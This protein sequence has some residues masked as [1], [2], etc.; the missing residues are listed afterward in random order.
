MVDTARAEPFLGDGEAAP[1]L[2]QQIA[3]WNP[4]ILVMDFRVAEIVGAFVTHDRDAT[5][6]DE[7][8]CIK[9]DNNL[10]GAAVED[11]RHQGW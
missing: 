1:F 2:T 5:G 6:V 10:A 4:A 8:G 3:L 9:G 7:A 11:F